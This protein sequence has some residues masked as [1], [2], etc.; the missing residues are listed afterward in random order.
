MGLRVEGQADVHPDLVPPGDVPHPADNGHGRV[1]RHGRP[2]PRAATPPPAVGIDWTSGVELMSTEFPEPKWAVPGLV[3][4][5]VTLLVGPPKVGK[6][7]M[8]LGLALSVAAGGRAL[9]KVQVS[10][11][12]VALLALEDTGRRLQHR[13]RM[14]LAGEAIPD[15]LSITTE[16][17]T[18]DDGLTDA[19]DE[20]DTAAL[21]LVIVDVLQRVR[22]RSGSES[23][24]ERD[25]AAVA[26]LK[27]WSDR[28]RVPVAVLHHTRKA[29][30]DDFLATVSGSH[31]LAG[32]A[33][34]VLVMARARNSADATLSITGRDIEEAEHALRFDATRGTWT[35][36]DGPA[37]DYELSDTRRRIL[38]VLREYA[39]PLG[40]TAV[41]E[42]TGLKVE[43]VKVRLRE[44]AEADQ[45]LQQGRGRYTAPPLPVTPVTSVTSGGEGNGGNGSN[46]G[47]G[48]PL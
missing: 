19:L 47:Q 42:V 4:E 43:V 34:A 1:D 2:W 23:V 35:L 45:V 15:G 13:L 39:E 28:H 22:P 18:L 21:R 36:L 29:G 5:G 32:A 9:G 14:L 12:K 10:A 41:A 27:A 30:S 48:L 26:A 46:G 6:S 7:W 37:S 38:D 25:Y 8:A 24:Y 16:A 20:L 31:G 44:M 11:G 3:A 17:P 40:P 33:D